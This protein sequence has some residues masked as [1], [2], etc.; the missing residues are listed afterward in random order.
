[1]KIYQKTCIIHVLLYKTSP[2]C[3]PY[4]NIQGGQEAEYIINVYI[5]QTFCFKIYQH[6]LNYLHQHQNPKI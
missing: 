5:F 4:N 1:M 2:G 3:G 6:S